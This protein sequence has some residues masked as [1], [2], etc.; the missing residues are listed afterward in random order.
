MALGGPA[1]GSDAGIGKGALLRPQ[2]A[3]VERIVT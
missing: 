2:R 3:A 1:G